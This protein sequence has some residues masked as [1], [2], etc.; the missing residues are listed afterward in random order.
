M[1]LLCIARRCSRSAGKAPAFADLE[2]ARRGSRAPEV[3]PRASASSAS[4]W[5]GLRAPLR[6]PGA[7]RRRGVFYGD[8]PRPADELRGVCP[9]IAAT[10]VAIASSPGQGRRLETLLE[11][12][13]VPHDVRI[14]P[15]RATAT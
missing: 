6:R 8:V 7:A 13:G 12:L 15:T 5:A 9:V 4:V 10:A 3:D 2:A 14:Y 1:R 11:A